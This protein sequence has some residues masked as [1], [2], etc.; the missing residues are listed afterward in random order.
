MAYMCSF[1]NETTEAQRREHL[2]SL[3]HL[4]LL[5]HMW[6]AYQLEGQGLLSRGGALT[7]PTLEGCYDAEEVEDDKLE[8]TRS[9]GKED[10]GPGEAKDQ[11]E[12]QQSQYMGPLLAVWAKPQDL[13]HHGGQ[14]SQ[15]EQEHQTEEAQVSDIANQ[16]V[17]D[18]AP[19]QE[20]VERLSSGSSRTLKGA[21]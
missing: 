21:G 20:R 6:T 10:Q 9:K 14:H 3:G 16:R 13:H 15:V 1:W 19:G 12:A 11:A 17:L 8:G 7:T 5:L 2:G 18:P 4:S